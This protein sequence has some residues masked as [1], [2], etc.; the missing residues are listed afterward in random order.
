[1]TKMTFCNE[2]LESREVLAAVGSIVACAPVPP[3]DR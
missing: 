2:L 3:T 1:M